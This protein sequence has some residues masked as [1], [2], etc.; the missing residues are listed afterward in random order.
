MVGTVALQELVDALGQ[1]RTGNRSDGPGMSN[2]GWLMGLAEDALRSDGADRVTAIAAMKAAR[3][4]L[5]AD[6]LNF[7]P[8]DLADPSDIKRAWTL[9]KRAVK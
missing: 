7:E 3:P 2:A 1:V 9:W 6:P 8:Y 5:L 4:V